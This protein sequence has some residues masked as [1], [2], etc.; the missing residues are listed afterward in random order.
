MSKVTK[1]IFTI[2]IILNVMFIG[3]MAGHMIQARR[4]APIAELRDI[5]APQREIIR[6]ERV[7]LA[8]IIKNPVFDPVAFNAQL[9]KLSAIQCDFNR[10]F[11]VQM[12]DRLQKMTPERRAEILDQMIQR[13]ARRNK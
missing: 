2:S 11:M 7:K 10:N 1:I 9:N 4:F 13:S 12:N 5:G 8:E 3:M 6:S